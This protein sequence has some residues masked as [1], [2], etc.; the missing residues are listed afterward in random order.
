MLSKIR[1][2]LRTAGQSIAGDAML[3]RLRNASIALVGA[4]AAVG[5]ALTFFISQLG[6]PAV[7]S[8]PIPGPPAKAGSVHDAVALTQSGS[9]ATPAPA[10]GI[11]S[12]AAVAPAHSVRASGHAGGHRDGGGGDRSQQVAVSPGVG[13]APAPPR[14]VAP[15]PAPTPSPVESSPPAPAPVTAV[16]ESP[17]VTGVAGVA[18]G[19]S[20]GKAKPSGPSTAKVTTDES[21]KSGTSSAGSK[22]HQ[23]S[24]SDGH[25][26]SSE[27]AKSSP[28]EKA[29]NDQKS[30]TPAAPAPPAK[31]EPATTSP[32]AS[33]EAADSGK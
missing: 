20:D 4:V 9:A 22:D 19:V 1:L 17:P 15:S 30:A 27:K 32:A 14:Q 25:T 16:A 23:V 13:H 7:F 28:A 8:G 5:L 33:K 12:P 2:Q 29:G 18:K 26:A 31:T 24:K 6:F 21:G 10:P 3:P 11:S